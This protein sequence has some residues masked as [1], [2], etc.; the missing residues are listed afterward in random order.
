MPDSIRAGFDSLSDDINKV[1][2]GDPLPETE[3]GIVSDKLKELTLTTKDGDLLTLT[4]KW[5]QNWEQ[6]DHRTKWV[7]QGDENEKYWLGKHFDR[8]RRDTKRSMTDNVLFEA[9]EVFLP[10]ATRR[11]PEPFISIHSSEKDPKG[12]VNPD[13][14]QY[15]KKVKDRLVDLADENILRLKL[16]KVARQSARIH[17]GQ[18]SGFSCASK[19]SSLS[20]SHSASQST[21]F[22]SAF[23]GAITA[24]P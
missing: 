15:I 8:A 18:V 1:K 12:N 9:L 24:C 19:S 14:E 21:F 13:H 16:K 3:E 11:N 4:K 7:E 23:F 17:F 6:S 20:F 5:E 10:Q 22:V 2:K